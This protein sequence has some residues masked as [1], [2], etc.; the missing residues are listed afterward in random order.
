M[1]RISI[2]QLQE[3]RRLRRGSAFRAVLRRLTVQPHDKLVRLYH[4]LC[5][6]AQKTLVAHLTPTVVQHALRLS[7]YTFTVPVKQHTAPSE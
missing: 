4:L 5:L 2:K 3:I 1:L 6:S 7:F